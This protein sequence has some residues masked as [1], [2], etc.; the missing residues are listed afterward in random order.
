VD[1]QVRTRRVHGTEQ[2][3][4]THVR[5]PD[6]DTAALLVGNGWPQRLTRGRARAAVLTGRYPHLSQPARTLAA[7]DALTDVDFALLCRAGD[8]F[9]THDATGLTPRQVPI[10]GLRAKWLNT[11]QH[12]V[13]ELAGVDDLR[14]APPHPPRLHFTYLDP[15]H[16]ARRGR[17]HDSATVG[18]PVALPYRPQVVIISENKD[19]AVHFPELPSAVSVEGVGRGGG[20]AAAFD[21]VT[22]A[23]AVFY[24][25]DMDPDGMEILDG[26]R[27]AGVPATSLLMGTAEYATWSRF[28]TDTDARGKALGPRTPRPVPCL[29]PDETTLYHQLCSPSW[30]G[31][32]RIEQ[33]RIPLPIAL[34]AVQA[35]LSL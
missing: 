14:L 19:T 15:D 30:T 33:E 27:A 12:L 6:V 2:E 24:W 34:A 20:T 8:W 29:N 4:P 28:G 32:R 21:W 25:G 10:E 18:D 7:V 23:P 9:A 16:R 13:R 31:P 26:F 1:L 11:R 35:E 3:L 17:R 5:V 22:T